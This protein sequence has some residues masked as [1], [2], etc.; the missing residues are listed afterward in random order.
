MMNGLKISVHEIHWEGLWVEIII[1][2]TVTLRRQLVHGD[3]RGC[4]PTC[5]SNVLLCYILKSHGGMTT[6][7]P[8]D[9]RERG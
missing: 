3:H 8:T 6:G 4:G 1:S 2:K 7:I 5:I 9:F